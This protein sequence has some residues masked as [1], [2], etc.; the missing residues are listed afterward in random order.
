M[1]GEEEKQRKEGS[2]GKFEMEF[3]KQK[4]YRVVFFGITQAEEKGKQTWAE[5]EL[6]IATKASASF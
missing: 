1:E 2:L 3:C 5:G 6:A 4:I